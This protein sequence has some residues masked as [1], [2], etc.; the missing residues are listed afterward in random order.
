MTKNIYSFEPLPSHGQSRIKITR[1][2]GEC[3]NLVFLST[4]PLQAS[5]YYMQAI[6]VVLEKNPNA[7][8]EDYFN[9]FSRFF[10][11]HRLE[12]PFMVGL[13]RDAER[14]RIGSRI[15]E[16]REQQGMTDLQLAQKTQI[17]PANLSR[18]E[19]G[20]FSAGLDILSRIAT[21]LGYKI[22]MVKL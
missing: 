8:I 15:K 2:S 21:A 14:A 16:I 20:K 1:P 22:D 13:D 11:Q 9:L 3:I 19:Q 10:A 6:E 4:F 17:N 18:I 12:M 5:D 7:S